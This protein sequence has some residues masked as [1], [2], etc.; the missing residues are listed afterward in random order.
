MMKNILITGAGRGLGLAIA[1]RLSKEDYRLICL[2]RTL[3]EE[4]QSLIDSS[5]DDV[6]F[7]QYDLQ[8]LDGI[9]SLVSSI[10]KKYGPLY[11]IINNA[12]IGLD[13]LLA[14]Q[15]ATDISKVLRVNLEAPILLTKY[16]CRSMLTRMEGRVINVSSIIAST[17]FNGLSVYAASKAG[18]E[19][20]TR[21]LSRELGRANITVNCIAPGY[22]ETEM[23]KGLEGKKLESVKRRAPLGLP[24]PDDV[25]GAVAYLLSA[26]SS[27]MTG[28]IM[29]IDGGSTA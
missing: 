16:A 7:Q 9:P 4:L 2:S 22:M 17:G 29:T 15:H 28:S 1:N 25:T 12:G 24:S 13:G 5:G 26:D 18:L 3:S 8:D 20:F 10:T 11:G 19:G 14:T 21:S 6:V 23:T 27:K